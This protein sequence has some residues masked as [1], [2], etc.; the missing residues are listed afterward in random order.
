MNEEQKI[1]SALER[2]FARAAVPECPGLAWD[3]MWPVPVR[4]RSRLH[5]YAYVFATLVVLVSGGI[6]AQAS[7]ALSAGFARLFNSG[8]SRPL[9]PLIHPA[10]RLTVAQA[11]QRIPFSIVAPVGL[12]PHSTF[13]YAEV[14]RREL[15]PNVALVYQTEIGGLYYRII[16]NET[17]VVHGSPVAHFEVEGKGKNDRMRIEKWTLPLR[18]WKHGAI[19]MEMLP[20]G[21]PRAVVDRIVRENT[22]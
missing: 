19:F 2:R 6:A 1:K 14:A 11:Q 17:T 22:L 21:L 18:V 3:S 20:Q 13:E 4:R 7:G 12:P 15:V 8:S 16:I 9:P 5:G 10:D